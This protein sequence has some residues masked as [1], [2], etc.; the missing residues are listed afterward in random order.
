M[1]S[2]AWFSQAIEAEEGDNEEEEEE[3][4]ERRRAHPRLRCAWLPA[5]FLSLMSVSQRNTR[6]AN[7]KATG[8]SSTLPRSG[9]RGRDERGGGGIYIYRSSS[10][11]DGES[12]RRTG[13]RAREGGS[14][15]QAKE[16]QSSSR[17]PSL[18]LPSLP[19]YRL[20][21]SVLPREVEPGKK[22]VSPSNSNFSIGRR[23]GKASSANKGDF[24]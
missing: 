20:R 14:E 9:K 24:V 16:Q 17:P 5:L 4:R 2:A 3:E 21:P 8:E 15:R 19:F 12:K 23:T 11:G 18:G 1:P 10:F 13:E 7:G 6:L 22:V